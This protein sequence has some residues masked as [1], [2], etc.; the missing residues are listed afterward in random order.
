MELSI[1]STLPWLIAVLAIIGGITFF[2]S[3]YY[4]VSQQPDFKESESGRGTRAARDLVKP[5]PQLKPKLEADL[6]AKR[7]HDTDPK[8][9]PKHKIFLSHS[10]AQKDF[11]E[12]LCEDLERFHHFPFFDKREDS[13][14]KGERFPELIFQ[15][16]KQCRVAVVVVSEEFLTRTKWPMLELDAFVKAKKERNGYPRILPLFFKLSRAQCRESARRE[17]WLEVWRG[18]ARHDSKIVVE[19][20]V[21][22]LNIFGPINGLEYKLE[23]EVSYR[24]AARSAIIRLVPPELQFDTTSYQ[25]SDRFCKLIVDKL[26]EVEA[27]TEYGVRVVGVYGVGGLGKT[28]VCKALYNSQYAEYDGRVC[29]VELGGLSPEELQKQVLRELTQLNPELEKDLRGDK[30]VRL[31]KERVHKHKVFLAI[32]N[33]WDSSVSRDAALTFLQAGFHCDSM[34]LVTARTRDILVRL[35]IDENHCIEMPELDKE[36]ATKLFL[37][38]ALPYCSQ[39]EGSQREVV[40]QCVERC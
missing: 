32:D 36:E 4:P 34:V 7:Q 26:H 17:L 12:Q 22:A 2:K 6:H 24:K 31:L 18:W 25:G 27:S 20:W 16:A 21:N 33:V 23:G 15:A 3:A 19:D 1:S 28:S 30:V 9:Q 8:L 10:G 40:E 38:H 37:H 39:V 5:E 29:L 14:P 35:D 13:L 11:V